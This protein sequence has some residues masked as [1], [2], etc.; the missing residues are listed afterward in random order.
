M[1][2]MNLRVRM[3]MAVAGVATLM[4]GCAVH[5]PDHC[6]KSVDTRPEQSR[7]L[8]GYQK[9]RVSFTR[10]HVSAPGGQMVYFTPLRAKRPDGPPV[11]V[12]PEMPALSPDVLKLGLRLSDAGYSVYV[13]LLWGRENENA[14]STG[15]FLKHAL[16]LK[17]SPRWKISSGDADRPVL[18]DI[19]ALYEEHIAPRHRGQRAGVVG[20]CLTGIFPFALAARIPQVAAPIASQ[21]SLPL[22]LF[23]PADEATGLSS[24]EIDRL[25]MRCRSEPSFQLLGFRFQED[26]VSPAKRFAALERLFG[27]RFVDGT[28]PLKLYRERDRLPPHPHSVLTACFDENRAPSTMHAWKECVAFLN[29]K[30]GSDGPREF[31]FTPY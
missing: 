13:P 20:N 6:K 30:L 21:P 4:Q 16:E 7:L 9:H 29:A 12:L 31:R 14:S 1:K 22:N 23:F 26:R 15:V 17:F 3:V 11:L 25:R 28:V 19:K 10:H 5:F 24:K 27:R 8:E 2:G 18:D